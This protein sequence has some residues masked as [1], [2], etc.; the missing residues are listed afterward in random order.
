MYSAPWQL[1]Y[2][3]KSVGNIGLSAPVFIPLLN[4][5]MLDPSAALEL[6][7]AAI[8]AFRRFHC[9]ADVSS[10]CDWYSGLSQ[11]QHDSIIDPWWAVV[12]VKRWAAVSLQLLTAVSSSSEVCAVA[13]VP[14]LP[15]GSRGQNRCIPAAPAMSWSGRVWSCEGDTEERDLQPRSDWNEG[16]LL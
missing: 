6:R 15:R 10:F 8:Q 1:F 16:V 7:I 12:E 2:A 9:S 14:L 13:A 5:F 3:L 11:K 4:R